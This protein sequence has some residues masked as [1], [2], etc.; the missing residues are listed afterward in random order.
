MHFLI[1]NGHENGDKIVFYVGRRK[2]KEKIYI[3]ACRI[4]SSK[5]RNVLDCLTC[6]KYV[7]FVLIISL[8]YRDLEIKKDKWSL[9]LTHPVP[10]DGLR[11]KSKSLQQQKYLNCHEVGI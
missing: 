2:R 10:I 6:L 5:N 7:F 1:K 8:L 9:Q 3:K 11:E 4:T